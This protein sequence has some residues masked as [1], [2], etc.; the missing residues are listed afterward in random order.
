MPEPASSEQ[1]PLN[2]DSSK[3]EKEI[4]SKIME[5]IQ[6]KIEQ[7]I[8]SD[9]LGKLEEKIKGNL[10]QRISQ[11]FEQSLKKIDATVLNVA[12]SFSQFISQKPATESNATKTSSPKKGPSE[13]V[14]TIQIS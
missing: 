12:S 1:L 13:A 9:L 10:D 7:K 6:A 14:P 3:F 11:T 5:K 4:E 2:M 8:E